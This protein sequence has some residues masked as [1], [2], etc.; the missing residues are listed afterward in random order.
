MGAEQAALAIFDGFKGQLTE[1][2]TEPLEEHNIHSVL[3]SSC[4]TD[5]LQPLDIS[6]N[7]LRNHFCVQTSINGMQIKQLKKWILWQIVLS[8]SLWTCHLPQ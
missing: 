3:V 7:K 5:R 8:L 4:Y 2:V 6:V 1:Q